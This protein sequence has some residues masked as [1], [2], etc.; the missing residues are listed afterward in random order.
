MWFQVPQTSMQ[1]LLM[2]IWKT[3]NSAFKGIDITHRIVKVTVQ[4]CRDQGFSEQEPV[5]AF[6]YVDCHEADK[7]IT[8]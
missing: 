1:F 4:I 6:A 5:I 8:V 7:R 2:T 3:K